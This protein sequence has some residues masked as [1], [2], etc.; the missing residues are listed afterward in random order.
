MRQLCTQHR[1]NLIACGLRRRPAK[2]FAEP[3][4]VSGIYKLEWGAGAWS[5]CP[6]QPGG[7]PLHTVTVKGDPYLTDNTDTVLSVKS[8]A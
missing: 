4:G 8:L 3:T 5:P 6:S 2:F 7:S 1:G